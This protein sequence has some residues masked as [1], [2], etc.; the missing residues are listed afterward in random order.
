MAGIHSGEIAFAIFN[1]VLASLIVVWVF[2]LLYRQAVEKTMRTTTGDGAPV[3][4]VPTLP[5]ARAASPPLVSG[6]TSAEVRRRLAVASGFGFA[7]SALA[8]SW[9]EIGEFTRESSGMQV[10]VQTFA[11]WIT[12]WSPAVILI[13]FMVAT[14]ARRVFLAFALVW[15]VGVTLVVALPGIARL[16]G[17][18]PL[19]ADLAMNAY[20]FTVALALNALPPLVLVFL[21]GRPRIRNVMPLVLALV[22]LLSL[23]LTFFDYW[24]KVSVSDVRNVNSL[25]RWAVGIFGITIG[26]ALLFLL[27][28]VPVGILGWW[29]IGRIGA[30]YEARKFSDIQLI[31]DAWWAVVIALHLV[32][33]WK[34][35]AV[36]AVSAC[37]AALVLYLVGVR[38]AVAVLRLGQRRPGPSLLL[39][40]VFGF[41]ERTER[42][43]DA[44]AARWRFEG[45]VAMIAGGDLAL[46]SID[47]GE[48][49]AFAR[50]DIDSSYVGDGHKLAERLGE[51]E[52]APD[53]DGRFRIAEFFCYEN[54]WRATLQSLVARSS[55]VLMDLRGFTKAN[56][57]CVFELQQ[58]AAA[59][60]LANC[61]FVTD[62][63]SDRALAA[64]T[65]GVRG[66]ASALWVPVQKLKAPAMK[67]LWEGLVSAARR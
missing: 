3:D 12:N 49:L 16:I 10:V 56:A 61:V 2:L 53:P 19:D 54:T 45:A 37:V 34:Y 13:G 40:R 66:G 44:V 11:I 27:L 7:L 25:L 48:A 47:A 59:G 57:G 29:A 46:R 26:P 30:R 38:L 36:I 58:L 67:M 60:R 51:L 42:L 65:L 39:L 63:A 21:T 6:P 31:V 9:P 64:S 41:Q 1:G 35:G 22:V 43:F 18:R 5:D 50:G 28:S 24:I 55:V 15:I 52:D 23:A 33:L 20:W 32:T 8:L 4:V 62:D 17:G 14:P